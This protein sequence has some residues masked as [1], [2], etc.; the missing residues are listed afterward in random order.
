M[1]NDSK[2][3]GIIPARGGS[4]G[5]AGKNIRELCGKPLLVW[6]I[7]QALA[8]QYLDDLIVST[9]SQEIAE[10]AKQNGVEVP[11]LRPAELAR[12]D[13]PSAD[14]VIHVLDR[15]YQSGKTY[16]YVALLEPTSP[17]RK[18]NDIDVAIEFSRPESAYRGAEIHT[19]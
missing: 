16:D 18:R 6:T 1:L 2:I 14:A 4:K 8:S 12:D 7:R 19:L 13:S 3:L 9:D 11:F 17:L 15:L 5:L 10:I